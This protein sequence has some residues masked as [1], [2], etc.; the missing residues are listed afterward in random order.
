[1]QDLE[2]SALNFLHKYEDQMVKEESFKQFLGRN[3]TVNTIVESLKLCVKYDNMENVK[4]QAFQFIKTNNENVSANK[5]Y[6]DLFKSHPHLMRD[7]YL[8]VC[9]K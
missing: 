8:H 1:M 9:S 6:L 7:V 5:E 2:R 4:L 3:I